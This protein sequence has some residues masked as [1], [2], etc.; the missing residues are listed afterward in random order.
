MERLKEY[1]FSPVFWVSIVIL[2]LSVVVWKVLRVFL[3]KVLK[4]KEDTRLPSMNLRV[5]ATTAK[6]AYILVVAAVILQING[7]NIGT[8]F[9]GLGVAGII[10]GFALQDVLK[11][12]MMGVSIMWDKFFAEGDYICYN[13]QEGQVV[14]FNAKV[15]KLK[16]Y[17]DDTIVTI[18]NRNITEISRA[19]ELVGLTIPAPYEVPLPRIREVM[20]EIVRRAKELPTVKDAQFL[21]T[22]EFA[23]S[24]INYKLL[25][26][27]TDP[28]V[29]NTA[30]RG[31]LDIVQEVFA[32]E[33]ITIPYPQMEVHMVK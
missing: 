19:S 12:L 13:G 9:A 5:L 25:L 1:L 6:S 30:R 24:A 7:I 4:L 23:D 17:A 28:T 32:Q 16:N 18:S 22:D 31:T 10:V 14:E 8:L 2:L 29:K 11:D 33:G 20:A 27:C 15:T 21:G 26:R 3:R